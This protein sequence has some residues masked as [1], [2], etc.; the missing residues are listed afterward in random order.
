MIQFLRD[1]CLKDLGLKLLSLALAI[2][3]YTT[4]SIF[5]IGNGGQTFSS[6]VPPPKGRTFH[7]L[8]IL[9]LSSA[10]DVR[11]FK[12]APDQVDVTVEGDAKTVA[13]LKESDIRALVDL[14][15]IESSPDLIRRIEI[16][17]PAGIS[18]I[19][20]MPPKVLVLPPTH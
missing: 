4:V 20:V 8:P 9:V 10:A 14:T 12:I 11:Q 6:L 15:G 16:S 7:N 1:L 13:Q 17:V 5:A 18:Q 3:I 2:L 19:R